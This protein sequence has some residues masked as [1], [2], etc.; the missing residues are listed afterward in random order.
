MKSFENKYLD[1][2]GYFISVDISY[3]ILKINSNN[4]SDTQT[5]KN[6]QNKIQNT[7]RANC[8]SVYGKSIKNLP[9]K[10]YYFSQLQSSQNKYFHK[11]TPSN[12]MKIFFFSYWNS[13][14]IFFSQ[15]IC[16]VEDW[17]LLLIATSQP[18]H[19]SDEKLLLKDEFEL[20]VFIL[21]RSVE[22]LI[23]H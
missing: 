3:H 2:S 14:G 22:C 19:R 21:N 18:R 10:A 8:I 20:N 5:F 11:T 13:S 23:I 17:S 16:W 12:P 4:C 1:V 15:Q 6:K 9:G 7:F